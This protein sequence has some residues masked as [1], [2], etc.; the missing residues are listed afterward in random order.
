MKKNLI[1]GMFCFSLPVFAASPR[2][3]ASNIH[4]SLT[5]VAILN[6][7]LN[8]LESLLVSEGPLAAAERVTLQENFLLKVKDWATPMTNEGESLDFPLNDMSATVVGF[9][10]DNRNFQGILSDDWIYAPGNGLTQYDYTNNQA[11]EDFMTNSNSFSDPTQLVGQVQSTTT[12]LGVAAGVLTTRGFG[13]AYLLDGTNRAP[14]RFTF[15]NF[16]CR[17]MEGMF[18]NKISD[19]FV[20]QDVP[21]DPGGDDQKYIASCKGCHSGMDPHSKAFSYLDFNLVDENNPD[22]GA[23]TFFTGGQVVPKVIQAADTSPDGYR[24]PDDNWRNMWI[25]NTEM[26]WDPTKVEG[27]GPASWGNMIT[28]AGQFQSCMAQ[29]VFHSTCGRQP[30]SAADKASVAKL[31]NDFVGDN[32]N[33]RRLF[34]RSAVVCMD[35]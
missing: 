33:L 24:T 17:D 31:A 2:Q 25:G 16:L 15:M 3:Q 10:R 8:V 27:S 26:G 34:A 35:E 9:V 13:E 11:Y 18:D 19:Q 1:L 14:V 30:I 4:N 28:S 5:G 32:Y 7:D 29:K 12:N 23:R 22:Q 6:E 20:R 21:R